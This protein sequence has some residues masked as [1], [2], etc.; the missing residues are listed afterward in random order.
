MIERRRVSALIA[1]DEPVL[2]AT[3]ERMLR[4]AWPQLEILATVHDGDAALRAIADRRPDIAFLDIRMPALSGLE[5]AM[6]LHDRDE[7]PPALVFVTA[8]D[9]YAVDAFDAAAV[10][11]LLKPVGADRLANCVA[12]LRR[13]FGTDADAAPAG[14]G[15]GGDAELR[16]LIAQL[17]QRLGP[18]GDD[19]PR[20]RFL[21]AS[22]GDVIR[23]IPIDEV[24]Y[25]EARDKY[26]AVA[27]R[28]ATA[29]VRLSLSE[30]LDGL[31]PEQFAQIHRSTLVRLDAIDTIRRDFA[32]R[33]WV[34]LREELAG[35]E[36][37]LAVSRHYAARFRGM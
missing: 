23:Q 3:L 5:V 1:E 26:V 7:P 21:R 14:P 17:Q 9:Q 37:R 25:F 30:L 13:R 35:R 22:L 15:A 34:H 12:R 19:R 29:L 4:A 16:A 28:D 33:S 24:L 20:L 36:I 10:D 32:G 27:T 11:Y 8:Y 6:R 2:A 18:A 31:D